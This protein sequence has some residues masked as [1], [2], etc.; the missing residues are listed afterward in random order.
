MSPR[1]RR[2]SNLIASV[3]I[4]SCVLPSNLR[5]ASRTAASCGLCA[6]HI[7]DAFRCPASLWVLCHAAL[8]RISLSSSPSS[9]SSGVAGVG[10]RLPYRIVSPTIFKDSSSSSSPGA[11]ANPQR[12]PCP[13]VGPSHYR[14]RPLRQNTA[15]GLE[16]IK[17]EHT[18]NSKNLPG[19][20]SKHC[21][22]RR[23]RNPHTHRPLRL[24]EVEA[25]HAT[26]E[27][28]HAA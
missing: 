14:H 16:S 3:H 2:A 4:P 24:S 22:A 17:L 27:P 6:P 19:A 26:R 25:T 8:T 13:P 9:P 1:C 15:S 23:L 12:K 28:A 21:T 20:G 11:K 7:P 10:T 18:Q 5:R